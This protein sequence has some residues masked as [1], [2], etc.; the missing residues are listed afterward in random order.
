[1]IRAAGLAFA[2]AAVV[3]CGGGGGGEPGREPAPRTAATA[4]PSSRIET[5][6]V[7][8]GA[9]GA[10]VLRPAGRTG[11]LPTVIFFHGWQA[12][13]VSNFAPWLEHLVAR[14]NQVIYP[15]Y[16]TATTGTGSFRGN[17]L[18]GIRA[19]LRRVR[20]RPGTLVA[21]GHSAGGALSSDYAA[22]AAASGLP[23]PR[24][25]F[26]VY[27]GR[28]VRG[29][30]YFSIPAADG[31]RIAPG[32]EIE[33]LGGADDRTVGT[34]A[35]EAVVDDATRVPKSRKRYVLIRDSEVSVHVAPL[36]TSP[37]ARRTFW[38]RLDRLIARARA[39]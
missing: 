20:I 16:Q 35:A 2:A 6:T 26:A 25:V 28:S 22:V 11:A 24:G 4:P 30:P 13:D 5:F 21:A 32:T 38:A 1:V 31:S 39:R 8:E 17:A 14:G 29:V 7:G 27:A 10:A 23:R 36:N 34:E 19:A 3:G 33:S 9:R 12:I 15:A 18:A 37:A